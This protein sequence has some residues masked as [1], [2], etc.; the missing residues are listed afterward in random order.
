M[1][2]YAGIVVLSYIT[3]FMA[4]VFFHA[5]GLTTRMRSGP[6]IGIT[7]G[8]LTV[9]TVQAV[10]SAAGLIPQDTLYRLIGY[11]VVATSGAM[12]YKLEALQEH[13]TP[14]FTR[15][16]ERYVSDKMQQRRDHDQGQQ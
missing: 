5:V 3:M 13:P 12:M 9:E 4:G 10:M 1:W 2:Q 7:V 6:W 11:G 8:I 14:D 16:I 15:V